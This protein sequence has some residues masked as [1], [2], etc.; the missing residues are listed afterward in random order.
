ML[1]STEMR[2][3]VGHRN[4]RTIDMANVRF[5]GIM[6][7]VSSSLLNLCASIFIHQQPLLP[8]YGYQLL[9]DVGIIV[10]LPPIST[11]NPVSTRGEHES[12]AV[13]HG[14][15]VIEFARKRST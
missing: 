10:V 14:A 11:G 13:A 6:V 2:A 7:H 3:T 4:E 8:I 9:V 1:S 15:M 12:V 5:P